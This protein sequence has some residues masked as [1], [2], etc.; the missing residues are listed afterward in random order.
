MRTYWTLRIADIVT[1]Y[2]VVSALGYGVE[3]NPLARYLFQHAGLIAGLSVMFALSYLIYL[4][5]FTKYRIVFYAFTVMSA[6]VVAGN[7][8]AVYLILTIP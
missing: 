8:Y 2:I 3:A 6:F 4:L 5:Y 7:S 1:T